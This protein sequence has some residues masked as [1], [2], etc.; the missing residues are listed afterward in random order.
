MNRQKWT[1]LLVGI[2]LIGVT[3]FALNHMKANQRLGPPGL[4]TTPIP[5]SKRLE[6]YLPPNVLDYKSE[7]IPTDT[8]V[9]NGL[10][11]D[12]SFAQRRYIA[13]DGNWL[14]CNV[15]LMGT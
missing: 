13:P 12:T 2:A 11:Q 7:L 6:I 9:L 5:G 4:K 8:N 14:L 15:V 1:C 3:A 10:P